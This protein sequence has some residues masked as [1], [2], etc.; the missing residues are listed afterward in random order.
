MSVHRGTTSV[1]LLACA[2]IAAGGVAVSPATASSVA[3]AAATSATLPLR[4]APGAGTAVRVAPLAAGLGLA[5]SGRSVRLWYRSTSWSGRPSLVTGTL[6]VPAGRPPKGGWPVISYAHGATGV[7]DSCAPSITGHWGA[8]KTVLEALLADGYAIAATD[9]EGLGTPGPSFPGQGTSEAF[10]IIDIVRAART[11][12]P[13]SRHWAAVG[14]SLGGHAALFTAALAARYA[15][16]LD[17][18]GSI[19]LAPVTQWRLQMQGPQSRDPGFPVDFNALYWATSASVRFP[20]RFVPEQLLTPRGLELVDQARELCVPDMIATVAGVTNGDVYRD[21]AAAA[22]LV[23]DLMSGDEVPIT[24][25]PRP[26]R[27]IQGD[28]D[29]LSALTSVTVAQLTAAGN[30]VVYVPVEGADHLTLPAV[31]VPQ[32]R[33]WVRELFST[34]SS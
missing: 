9:Y 17:L 27:V 31:A 19:A 22:D 26:V 6:D 3:N 33:T 7:G 8:E 25:Y 15:P 20:T 16:S 21:P 12:A 4:P 24:R 30:D 14:Y 18:R 5:G 10:D 29:P 11:V 1:T 34:P 32:V 2:V 23:A 13:L 28:A